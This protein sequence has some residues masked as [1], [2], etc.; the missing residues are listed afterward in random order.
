MNIK[1]TVASVV[2][3]LTVL[4]GAFMG[5]SSVSEKAGGYARQ[6]QMNA[7]AVKELKVDVQNI[8]SR[9]DKIGTDIEW[10]KETLRQKL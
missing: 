5:F 3:I 9:T 7:D 6:I 10:I 1:L 8:I 2:A 4:G